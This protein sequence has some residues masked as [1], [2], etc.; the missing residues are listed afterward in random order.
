MN[1]YVK[2]LYE[3][4]VERPVLLSKFNALV[5]LSNATKPDQI[6]SS[7]FSKS[8]FLVKADCKRYWN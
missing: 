3:D 7:R 6:F 4:V 8:L 5:K 1:Q 2:K